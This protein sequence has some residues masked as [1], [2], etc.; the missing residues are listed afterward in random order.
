MPPPMTIP[1]AAPM[2]FAD[3]FAGA[4]P[5]IAMVH[6]GATPGTPRSQ[7]GMLALARAAAGEAKLLVK[8]G[9]RGLLIENMHDAPYVVGPHDPALTATMTLAARA[10]ADAAPG[11]VLGV[12]VL[13]RGER[14][15]LS[16]CMAAEGQF[17]RCENFVFSHVADEGLMV[18]AAAGPLLRYRREVGAQGVHI[19]ADIKKKHASHAITMDITLED[20]VHGAA[21]FG[22]DG[23]V[24]TG[25]AT[26]RPAAIADVRSAVAAG[27][28]PVLVG[29]G[30]TRANVKEMLANASGAVVGSSL[31]VGGHWAGELDE[32]ACEGLV[33]AAS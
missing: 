33:A 12:Q 29:S 25:A 3:R 30:V 11:V 9:F 26:G 21:F 17:V 19:Y 28:L 4:P 24:V 20:V 22:A 14:E 6:V 7:R 5:L 8:C 15:A 13:A 1:R 32:R 27:G 2:I 18:D 16:I 31:K 23:V 10:V